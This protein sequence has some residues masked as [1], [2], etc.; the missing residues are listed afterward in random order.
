MRSGRSEKKLALD[1]HSHCAAGQAISRMTTHAAL[2]YPLS[3][4]AG[5]L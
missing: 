1:A 5:M 3:G 4:H 2:R